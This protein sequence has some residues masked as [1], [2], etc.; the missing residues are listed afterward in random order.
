MR[1]TKVL[2]CAHQNIP[3]AGS[4]VACQGPAPARQRCEAFLNV[5]FSRSMYAVLITPSPCDRRR[6]VSTRRRA[7]D[8]AAFGR[9]HMPPL[10]VFDDLGDQDGATHE[11]VAVRPC[12][13]ARDRETSPHGADVGYRHP[14][15]RSRGSPCRTAPDLPSAAG[16]GHVPLRTDLAAQPQAS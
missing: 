12:P 5:A 16:S 3:R 11:A 15:G 14:Y 1:S 2:H 10:V 13:C 8:N 9:D 6:R 4:G 7:I